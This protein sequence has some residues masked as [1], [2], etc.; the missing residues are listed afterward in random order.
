VGDYRREHLFTLRQSLAAFHHYQELIAA[1]DGEIA[2]SLE[3]FESK[4]DPTPQAPHHFRKTSPNRRRAN[5][6]SSCGLISTASS[7]WI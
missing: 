1:C 6:A 3:E 4:L 2:Q 5:R 7:V